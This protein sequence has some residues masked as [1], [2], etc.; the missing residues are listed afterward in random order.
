MI[1]VDS[2]LNFKTTLAFKPFVQITN[3]DDG[4]ILQQMVRLKSFFF[5]ASLYFKFKQ[6]FAPLL[7]ACS[8]SSCFI[9]FFWGIF[10]L[11]TIDLSQSCDSG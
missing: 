10:M 9:F 1:E 7:V 11:N 2:R 6:K 8:N 3:I 4:S 5:M